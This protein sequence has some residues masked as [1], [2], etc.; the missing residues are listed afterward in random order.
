MANIFQQLVQATPSDGVV[1]ELSVADDPVVKDAQTALL[2]LHWKLLVESIYLTSAQ[3]QND[4]QI[5]PFGA[6]FLDYP[7]L[8]LGTTFV[9]PLKQ[10]EES[11]TES[12]IRVSYNN[13]EVTGELKW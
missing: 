6:C 4:R 2:C 5:L 13:N 11:E 12:D 10:L 7:Q 3:S 1:G 8:L 9:L